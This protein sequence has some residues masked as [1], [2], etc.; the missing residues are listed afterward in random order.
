ME[1]K[2]FGV[3]NIITE[4]GRYQNSRDAGNTYRQT[5]DT[6]TMVAPGSDY[7]EKDLRRQAGHTVTSEEEVDRDSSVNVDFQTNEV[8]ALI[9]NKEAIDLVMEKSDKTDTMKWFILSGQNT[10]NVS[11]L[12]DNHSSFLCYCQTNSL[13]DEIKNAINANTHIH[14][15]KLDTN[16][17]K[18][19]VFS[20][21]QYIHKLYDKYKIEKKDIQLDNNIVKKADGLSTVYEIGNRLYTFINDLSNKIYTDDD[22]NVIEIKKYL[23]YILE[24]NKNTANILID[25]IGTIGFSNFDIVNGI[26]N[27]VG[28]Q[29][30][31]KTSEEYTKRMT[32]LAT[33]NSY[34]ENLLGNGSEKYKEEK[35]STKDKKLNTNNE[36][37]KI[38]FFVQGAIEKAEESIE[39]R[40]K[41]GGVNAGEAT[42]VILY[43]ICDKI[44]NYNKKQYDDL[45][46]LYADHIRMLDLVQRKILDDDIKDKCIKLISE[47]TYTKAQILLY[48]KEATGTTTATTTAHK[49]ADAD[50][51]SIG[52]P[53]K[54]DLGVPVKI[55]DNTVEKDS[56]FRS[57]G[58]AAK[59]LLSADLDPA[60][61]ACVNRFQNVRNLHAKI[62]STIGTSIDKTTNKD[63]ALG[64]KISQAIANGIT[65]QPGEVNPKILDLEEDIRNIG[66]YLK[67]G[68]LWKKGKQKEYYNYK[69][70]REG[71]GKSIVNND[72]APNGNAGLHNVNSSK[73]Y[74]YLN[75]FGINEDFAPMGGFAEGTG[76]YGQVG[77][78][79]PGTFVNPV[80][81]DP[82][83]PTPDDTPF[84][85]D[86][87]K[88]SIT[89]SGSGDDFCPNKKKKNIFK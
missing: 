68:G 59:E 7:T 40:S 21:F 22:D 80:E 16:L 60:S 54:L 34:A 88:T 78:R 84:D 64:R 36:N 8:F 49:A 47:I 87:N 62:I 39:E 57:I 9:A 27:P 25:I 81:G 20:E 38:I 75:M 69:V 24:L 53:Y 13:N 83:A 85:E 55:E 6:G 65:L 51:F 14:F 17:I 31:I 42:A 52:K 56:W 79:T 41:R 44:E 33:I 77:E 2:I 71:S 73:D 89:Q 50:Y 45:S 11:A 70:N 48:E 32:A 58:L 35:E 43:S 3:E 19:A 61:Q 63:F 18:N 5:Y 67:T 15:K 10:A 86:G 23:K 29:I 28:E 4:A 72:K 37:T 74:S 12:N 76:G 66:T 1:L 46:E 82:H 26:I 30:Q